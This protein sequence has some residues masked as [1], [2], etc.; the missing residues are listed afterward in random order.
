MNKGGAIEE[1]SPRGQ[2]LGG[3]TAAEQCAGQQEGVGRWR[4]PLEMNWRGSFV[5]LAKDKAR[6]DH[7]DIGWR[8]KL[9]RKGAEETGGWTTMFTG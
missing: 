1:G 7:E 5:L 8:L 9:R 2:I 4:G 3:V 6:C